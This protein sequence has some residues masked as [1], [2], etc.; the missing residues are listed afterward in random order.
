VALVIVFAYAIYT[1]SDELVTIV[2][3]LRDGL[4]YVVLAGLALVAVSALN[5]AWLYKSLFDVVGLPSESKRILPVFLTTRFVMVAAPSGGLSGWVPFIN[6]ARQRDIPVGMVIVVNLVY[7]VLWY[8]SFAIFLFAGLI[9]LFLSHD[10]QWFEVTAAVTLLFI[11]VLMI[12]G[13]VLALV[14]PRPLERILLWAM[15]A[16]RAVGRVFRRQS[17]VEDENVIGFVNDLNE[18][19]TLMRHAGWRKLARPVGHALGVEGLN[20]AMFYLMFLAFGLRATF[21]LLV[22]GYSVSILFFI[23]SPTPGGLGFVES[24]LILVLTSLG[25]PS[26]GATVVTLAYRGLTFWIPFVL[27]FI[28]LRWTTKEPESGEK[29]AFQAASDVVVPETSQSA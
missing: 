9:F 22:A 17:S 15:R 29:E 5:Q 2:D 23:I 7:M 6:D 20:L 8:S 11:D 4:W 1:Y 24:A 12:G 27:G 3:V 18:A 26:G 21:G 10:L 13:L 25:V 14:A 16:I 28:A 19:T